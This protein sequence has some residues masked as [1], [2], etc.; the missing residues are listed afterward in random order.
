MKK[1]IKIVQHK[2]HV[3]IEFL[4]HEFNLQSTPAM[5]RHVEKLLKKYDFPHAIFDIRNIEY[6]DSIGIGFF[7]SIRNIFKEHEKEMVL[8]CDNN[9]ILQ[10]L[11]NVNMGRFCKI[12]RTMEESVEL[13]ENHCTATS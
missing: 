6:I 2:S 1:S 12:A 11:E 10:V 8:L 13:I 9:R 7:I 4:I 5:V 3:L